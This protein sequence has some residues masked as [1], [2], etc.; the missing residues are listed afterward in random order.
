M[1]NLKF[2]N[3]G[4]TPKFMP[5]W[6]GPFKVLKLVGP[7]DPETNMVRVTTAVQLELPPMMKVH[8]V[9]HLNLVKQYKSD[10]NVHPPEPLVYEHDGSAQ[11]E[12]DHLLADRVRKNVNGKSQITE[13]LVRW[14]GFGAEHDTW[15]PRAN[16]HASLIQAYRTQKTDQPSRPQ[17]TR[18][19]KTPL[20]TGTLPT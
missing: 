9:F 13:Y 15:E 11:W 12:V 5:K 10:G 6:V 18:K 17:S 1:K 19:R 2:K 4:A 14:S 8:D 20:E 16:I 3:K 7:R